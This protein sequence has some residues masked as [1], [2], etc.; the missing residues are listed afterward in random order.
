MQSAPAIR[1]QAESSPSRASGARQAATATASV[2][3]SKACT[4]L[5]PSAEITTTIACGPSG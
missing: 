4:V 3:P 5:I 2:S 1:R